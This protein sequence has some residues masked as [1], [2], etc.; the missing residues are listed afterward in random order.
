MEDLRESL[1]AKI[2]AHNPKYDLLIW[3]AGLIGGA[4]ITNLLAGVFG[5]LLLV[6]DDQI[7]NL[8]LWCSC[9]TNRS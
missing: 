3:L 1:E 7:K 8:G 2:D 5:W 6:D 4:G 9:F